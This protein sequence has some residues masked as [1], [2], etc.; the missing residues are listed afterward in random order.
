MGRGLNS[1]KRRGR[2]LE[3]NE[4]GRGRESYTGSLALWCFS[5]HARRAQRVSPP[6]RPLPRLPCWSLDL[7]AKQNVLSGQEE[8]PPDHGELTPPAHRP[9]WPSRQADPPAL[10]VCRIPAQTGSRRWPF[11]QFIRAASEERAREAALGPRRSGLQARESVSAALGEG[12]QPRA[13]PS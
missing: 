9:E 3:A 4:R 7:P 11:P 2:G 8:H 5:P 6:A 13:P 10:P 1:N 12:P